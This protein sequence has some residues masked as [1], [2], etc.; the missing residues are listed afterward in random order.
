MNA[1]SG[2]ENHD[3]LDHRLRDPDLGVVGISTGSMTGWEI[4]I[5][6]DPGK[7]SN[8]I[9]WRGVSMVN[10]SIHTGLKA[11]LPTIKRSI[12]IPPGMEVSKMPVSKPPLSTDSPLIAAE[13]FTSMVVAPAVTVTFN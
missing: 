1:P 9:A 3:D 2:Y 7:D 4:R 8:G 5:L 10:S 6:G 11:R 12:P 13:Q